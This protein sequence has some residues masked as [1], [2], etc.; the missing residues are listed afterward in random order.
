MPSR[1]KEVWE[2]N[3]AQ[4]SEGQGGECPL[5]IQGGWGE[6]PQNSRREPGPG[7]IGAWAQA[8]GP[9][10]CPNMS[11]SIEKKLSDTLNP[12]VVGKFAK[13]NFRTP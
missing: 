13:K 4:N 8:H 6:A 11:K 12:F 5:R 1:I 3:A 9:G 10:P 7:P 2:A